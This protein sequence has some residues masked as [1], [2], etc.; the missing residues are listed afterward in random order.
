M[1]NSVAYI[2]ANGVIRCY[3][4]T[5]AHFAK[6]IIRYILPLLDTTAKCCFNDITFTVHKSATEKEIIQMWMH[7]SFGVELVD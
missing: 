2:D 5:I 4:G 7:A 1:M 6:D 3:N